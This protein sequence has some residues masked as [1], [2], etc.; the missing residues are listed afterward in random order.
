MKIPT[1][2]HIEET[3]RNQKKGFSI[4]T[5]KYYMLY[6]V[7]SNFYDVIDEASN[8]AAF[9]EKLLYFQIFFPKPLTLTCH[10]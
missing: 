8:Q 6:A 9:K 10:E 5:G 1:Q 2:E 3:T 7:L 4:G